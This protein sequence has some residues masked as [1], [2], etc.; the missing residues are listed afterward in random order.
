MVLNSNYIT[1]KI[2]KNNNCDYELKN[3]NSD[4]EIKNILDYIVNQAIINNE[5]QYMNLHNIDTVKTINKKTKVL[6]DLIKTNI[7]CPIIIENK[8]TYIDN[9]LYNISQMI[10]VN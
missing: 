2:M 5:L 10:T 6:N 9:F 3:N 8:N 4:N 7:P 1:D